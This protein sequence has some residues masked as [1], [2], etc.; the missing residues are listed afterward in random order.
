[1][2][3]VFKDL[4]TRDQGQDQELDPRGQGRGLENQGQDQELT[5]EAKS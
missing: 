5:F 4:R 3:A 2:G 1:L